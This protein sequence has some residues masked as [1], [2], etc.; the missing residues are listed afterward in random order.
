M[1]TAALTLLLLCS[2]AVSA[3]AQDTQTYRALLARAQAGDESVD[4]TALRKAWAASPE[5]APYGSDADEHADS[6]RAALERSDWARAIREAD[7]V[8]AVTWLDTDAH[9]MKAFA[10]GRMGDAPAAERERMVAR[11]IVQSVADSGAGTQQSPFVVVTVAEEY[12]YLRMNGFEPSVQGL[13]RCGDRE[14]DRMDAVNPDT[15]ERRTFYF[16]ITLP[17]GHLRRSLGGGGS[18]P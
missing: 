12:A 9:V 5:Y 18:K 1:R 14:C 7:A 3:R 15:S 16:D 4:F 8:L 10:A 2:L 13:D 11:R 17:A 6:M